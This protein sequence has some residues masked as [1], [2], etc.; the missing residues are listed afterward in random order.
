MDILFVPIN[1]LSVLLY[2][3]LCPRRLTSI[4]HLD[5]APLSSDFCLALANRR[6]QG[7]LKNMGREVR[8]FIPW[9]ASLLGD[10]L[11]KCVMEGHSSLL[12]GPVLQVS[13]HSSL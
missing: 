7:R 3:A 1:L 2:C 13:L 11:A 12:G 4:S 10:R 5:R 8:V 9:V 6:H